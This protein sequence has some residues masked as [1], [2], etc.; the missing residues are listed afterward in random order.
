MSYGEVDPDFAAELL[1]KSLDLAVERIRMKAVIDPGVPGECR[2]CEEH[3]TRLIGGA[4]A[5]CRD[6]YK[7][8]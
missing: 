3:F 7:L 8:P 5:R 1:Q 2:L 6:Q 4:C